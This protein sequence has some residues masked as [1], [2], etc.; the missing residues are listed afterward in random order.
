MLLYYLQEKWQLDPN[1]TL[2]LER[3]KMMDSFYEYADCEVNDS[4]I[5][6]LHSV[7]SLAEL[8]NFS[9]CYDSL[10]FFC[11]ATLLLCNGNSSS[12][13][14]TEEC[15]EVRD[16]KCASEWRTVESFYNRPIPDCISYADG[17]NLLF[18]KAPPFNCS[19]DFEAIC[20]AECLPVC[21]RKLYTQCLKIIYSS[22]I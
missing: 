7:Y 8:L 6:G 17:K 18:S 5:Y 2:I 19:N 13:N 21:E 12:I 22:F 14:L 10:Q 1:T 3:C 4:A 9:K 20:G 11:E 15:E 16:K